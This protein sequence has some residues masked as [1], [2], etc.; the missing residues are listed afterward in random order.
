MLPCCSGATAAGSPSRNPIEVLSM[1]LL[2]IRQPEAIVAVLALAGAA[3]WCGCEAQNPPEPG[4]PTTT[5]GTLSDLK[6]K[7]G[8]KISE[9]GDKAAAIGVKAADSTGKAME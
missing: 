7:A 9:V 2:R 8:E 5:R 1:M 4:A 3:T 6:K